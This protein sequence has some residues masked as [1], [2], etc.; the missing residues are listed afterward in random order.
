MRDNRRG[1]P[2]YV[3]LVAGF[4][5][6]RAISRVLGAIGAGMVFVGWFVVY[7]VAPDY[8]TDYIEGGARPR[9]ARN[10]RS[11]MRRHLPGVSETQH[12]PCCALS[13]ASG[14]RQ[15][16]RVGK[17]SAARRFVV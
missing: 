12:R 9:G 14:A 1:Q 5:V 15:A 4:Y 10:P 17:Q 7:E 2:D 13:A 6:W 16:P 3:N 8:G 11:H